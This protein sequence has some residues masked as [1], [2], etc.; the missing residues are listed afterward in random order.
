MQALR[1]NAKKGL[2]IGMIAGDG[3]GR[4]VLP[5]SYQTRRLRA[6]VLSVNGRRDAEFGACCGMGKSVNQIRLTLLLSHPLGYFRR[7]NHHAPCSTP[8]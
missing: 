6:P 2:K 1:E 4:I 5:V 3:I 7:H 8:P